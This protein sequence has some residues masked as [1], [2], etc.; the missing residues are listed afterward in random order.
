MEPIVNYI[1]NMTNNSHT[2]QQPAKIAIDARE[3]SETTGTYIS[4]LIKYLQ[5]IDD[6]N[7]YI[8]LLNP[9]D[10]KKWQPTAK[11]FTV[12]TTKY[13]EFTLGEQLG[14][15]KQLY[16]LNVDLVH[17]GMTQQPI[18]YFKKSVT[19]IHDLTTMRFRNPEKNP[20]V[21][22][23]KQF[24]YKIVGIHVCWKNK[25]IITATNY[26]KKDVASFS[27]VNPKKIRVT[28]EAADF[29]TDKPTP[30]KSLD[31]KP[32]IMYVG[33]PHPHKNLSRLVEA[34]SLVKQKN[35]TLK[36]V[37]AGK[38][39][40]IHNQ[41]IEEATTLGVIDDVLFTG[42]VSGGELK[43]LYQNCQAYVFPSLSEGFGLPGLEAMAHGAPVASS[44]ATCLPEVHGNAA[45]YFDPT[46]TLEMAKKIELVIN[47]PK[48]KSK[49]I[50]AGKQQAAKY[51]WLR[52]AKQT[53]KI[54]Q[55]AL[56]K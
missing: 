5:K 42:F 6:K 48:V 46:N 33:R 40:P 12:V 21:F 50:A 55:D 11:N 34:F 2:K 26:V 18:L 10:A 31:N 37:I 16:D 9:K 27:H 29:I 32:F 24:V 53:Q 52:M 8:I 39:Y 35:P 54:Y 20:I 15:A 7:E 41:Y 44:N 47:N 13:K 49:L 19:T 23:V 51:S 28:P 43:W 3:F 36:L 1:S 45:I 56:K 14:F 17:F 38:K 4:N 25:Y 30:V 22:T